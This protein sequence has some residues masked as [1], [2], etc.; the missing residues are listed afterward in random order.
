MLPTFY[1][2]GQLYALDKVMVTLIRLVC[3][4]N[5]GYGRMHV[6]EG[7]EPDLLQI[8]ANWGQLI[9]IA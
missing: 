6:K 8:F 7:C 3:F 4:M 1:F 2:G 9:K 5:N